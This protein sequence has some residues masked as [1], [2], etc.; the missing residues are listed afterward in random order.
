LLLAGVEMSYI[1]SGFVILTVD[2]PRPHGP[3]AKFGVPLTIGCFV[4]FIL[5]C[6]FQ[7][8]LHP[9]ALQNRNHPGCYWLVLK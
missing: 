6:S 1:E 3:L 2:Y 7:V 5:Q 4:D 8:E 9:V